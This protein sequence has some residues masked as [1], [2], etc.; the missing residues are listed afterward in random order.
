LH[1]NPAQIHAP[2]RIC[3]RSSGVLLNFRGVYTKT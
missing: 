2:A 3:V 1:Q